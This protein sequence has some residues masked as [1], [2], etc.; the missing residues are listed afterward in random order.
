MF[1]ICLGLLAYKPPLLIGAIPVLLVMRSQTAL[2][3]VTVSALGQV[4]ISVIVAGVEPWLV[5]FTS[6]R[7]MSDYYFLTDTLPHQKQSILGF[8]QLLFG[9]GTIVAILSAVSIALV[10][11]LWWPHRRDRMAVWMVPMLATTTVL[12][13]P[14][15]YVYDLVILMPV[16]VLTAGALLRTS[17]STPKWPLV[18]SGYALLY[19]PFSGAFALHSRVQASTIVLVAFFVAAHRIWLREQEVGRIG[20]WPPIRGT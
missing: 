6:L 7:R 17:D 11:A 4:A 19:A 16:L 13:S 14:H 2:T 20:D 3:G 15:F 5:Y 9:S 18:W 10:A 12:L 8:F 1:G